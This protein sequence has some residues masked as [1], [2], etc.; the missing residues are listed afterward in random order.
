MTETGGDADDGLA[1][2]DVA[3]DDRPGSDD[4]ARAGADSA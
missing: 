4:G 1:G 3:G 2:R